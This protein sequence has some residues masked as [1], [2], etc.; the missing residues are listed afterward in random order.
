VSKTRK[1][2]FG[3]MDVAA[4]IGI[5]PTMIN[6]FIERKQK[7]GIEASVHSGGRGKDRIFSEK[8]LYGIALVHWLFESGL[9]AEAI[10]FVLNQICGGRLHSR[11]NDAAEVLLAREPQVLAIT[12]EPRTHY[13]RHPDQ[14]THLCDMRDAVQLVRDALTRNVLLIPVGNLLA[15]LRARLE[16]S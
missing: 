12:R 5:Q 13:A 3:S 8:D 14:R 2:E 4:L 16:K 10:Q 1:T 9:R 7:Y 6:K 15:A 11:A